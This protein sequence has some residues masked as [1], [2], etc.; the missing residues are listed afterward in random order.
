MKHLIIVVSIII[1][2]VSANAQP[3][4][5]DSIKINDNISLSISLDELIKLN[6]ISVRS[7]QIEV[8]MLQ[9]KLYSALD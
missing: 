6:L 7:T 1:S 4:I 5:I 9:D 3:I 2:A 8:P